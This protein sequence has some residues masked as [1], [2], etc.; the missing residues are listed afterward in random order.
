MEEFEPDFDG[1]LSGDVD[2]FG[3]VVRAYHAAVRGTLAAR[4]VP[5][6]DLEDSAQEVFLRTFRGLGCFRRGRPFWPWLRSI[7]HNVASEALRKRA[8]KARLEGD[9]VRRRLFELEAARGGVSEGAVEA[10]KKCLGRLSE[11]SR[12]LVSAHY[13]DGSTSAEL[14]GREGLTS[15]GIR[16]LLC[17]AR[18][19]LRDCLR[20][21]LGLE[22][23]S[24]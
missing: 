2:A 17:R 16:N 1:I 8:R 10:L 14:A 11:R 22:G 19:A 6:S 12:R 13:V 7:A 15:S 21:T 9:A 4:G 20:R 3:T 5:R 23:G 18:Q 24:P